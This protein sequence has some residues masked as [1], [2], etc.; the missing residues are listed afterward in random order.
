MFVAEF[1]EDAFDI[2]AAIR[3]EALDSYG[4]R[5][6]DWSSARIDQC[7]ISFEFM[8]DLLSIDFGRELPT[9]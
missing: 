2:A 6:I 9:A 3:L 1:L 7:N 4:F 8:S 5:H